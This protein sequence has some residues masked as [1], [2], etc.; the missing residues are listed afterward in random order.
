MLLKQI[1]KMDRSILRQSNVAAR[2]FHNIR[3]SNA[4]I[5]F[6]NT[7]IHELWNVNLPQ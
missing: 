7:F 1:L 6:W 5:Y 2:V 4:E 3:R